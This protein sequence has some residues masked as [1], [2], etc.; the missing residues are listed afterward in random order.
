MLSVH[1]KL[2]GNEIDGRGGKWVTIPFKLPC[3]KIFSDKISGLEM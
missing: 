2:E 3:L 1:G